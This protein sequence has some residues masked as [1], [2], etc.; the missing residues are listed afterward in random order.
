MKKIVLIFQSKLSTSAYTCHDINYLLNLGFRGFHLKYIVKQPLYVA[1]AKI[2]KII[3][4]KTNFLIDK[5]LEI[6]INKKKVY[7][8]R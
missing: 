4:Q 7:I 6:M 8:D 3:N 5:L 1:E 2:F